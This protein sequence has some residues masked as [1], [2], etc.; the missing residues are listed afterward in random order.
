MSIKTHIDALDA[1]SH[2]NDELSFIAGLLADSNGNSS[3]PTTGLV[4]LLQRFSADLAAVE[5]AL[6]DASLRDA[7][8]TVT[9]REAKKR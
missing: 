4:F 6:N 1:I 8:N 7:I 2:L 5:R 3:W 9:D